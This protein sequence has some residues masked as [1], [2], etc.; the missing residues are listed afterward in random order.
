MYDADSEVI[1]N[2]YR[3]YDPQMG[4]YI[5]SDPIGLAGGINTYAYAVANPL[6][7]IDPVGLIPPQNVPPVIGLPAAQQ[8]AM[9]AQQL[10][11]PNQFY[12]LVRGRGA[13]DYK[14]YDRSYQD[15]GNYNFGVVAAASGFFSLRTILKQAGRAQCQAGASSPKWGRPELGPPYGDDPDDQ[16]WITEGWNDYLSGMYGPPAPARMF[17]L[18]PRTTDYYSDHLQKPLSYCSNGFQCW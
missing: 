14:Q 1:Y 13:W 7:R 4:R 12:D 6:T 10:N 11:N 18:Y 3:T 17:G 16:R 5:E 15:F 2:Y 8:N 9:V